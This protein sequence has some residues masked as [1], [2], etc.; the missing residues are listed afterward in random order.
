MHFFSTL[1]DFAFNIHQTTDWYC[2][3]EHKEEL[4][5]WRSCTAIAN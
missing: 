5:E 2:L 1:K 4:V 3:S